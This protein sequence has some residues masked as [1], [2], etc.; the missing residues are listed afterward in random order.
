MTAGSGAALNDLEVLSRIKN[1]DTNRLRATAAK[2]VKEWL[3]GDSKLPS[4]PEQGAGGRRRHTGGV[5]EA[6]VPPLKR[7]ER[8]WMQ[9]EAFKSPQSGLKAKKRHLC[10]FSPCTT[11]E[12]F[13]RYMMWRGDIVP[14][15][16]SAMV[17]P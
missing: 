12:R 6:W 3:V 13:E 11:H 14:R 15:L 16:A 7:F 4:E 17:D 9:E 1:P 8:F 5:S 10:L 2:A